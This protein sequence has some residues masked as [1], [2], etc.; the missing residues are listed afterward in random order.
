MS[1]HLKCLSLVASGL[2][3][4][5]SGPAERETARAAAPALPAGPVG[6]LAFGDT[7]YHYDYLDRDDYEPGETVDDY[8]AREREEWIEDRR[9]I[10]DFD[11]TPP[12]I[13]PGDGGVVATSGLG[14]VSRA[15]KTYCAEADCAWA[16]MLGDNVYPDGLTLGADGLDDAGRFRTLFME[17]FGTLGGDRDDFRIY[18]ALGNHD[19]KISRAA[20]EAQIEWLEKNP[21]FYMDGA[22]YRVVPAGSEGL[23]E[24]FVLDTTLLLA[25]TTVYEIEIEED[26][27]ETLLEDEEDEHPDGV[28]Q[29]SGAE[30]RMA[31]WLEEA[32]ADSTARWKIVT[33]HHALWSSGGSKMEQARVLRRLILPAL[34]RHADIYFAGHDHTLEAHLD[35]CSTETPGAPP[36]L[37][38]VSGAGAKQR[39][40][41]TPLVAAQQVRNP[42]LTTLWTRGMVW[43]F[44]HVTLEGDE[45]VLRIV[46][47]PQDSSGVPVE[48]F[49]YRFPRRSGQ[50]PPTIVSPPVP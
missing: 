7:G 41:H 8:V 32:L 23:V 49:V 22:F 14:P 48:D 38:V 43:G 5:C 30:R 26:G 47:T 46:S 39:P 21:P 15:M 33:G 24:I 37:Q 9:P 11:Y 28:A 31:I 13:L 12:Y 20:S 2:L 17:P 1:A 6:F 10:A 25:T 42:Q 29:L 19:W 16:V 27:S 50:I 18:A 3:V 34:C 4:A 40:L 35:D 45:A 36:F 44:A